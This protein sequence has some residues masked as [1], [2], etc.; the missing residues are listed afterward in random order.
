MN[1]VISTTREEESQKVGDHELVLIKDDA[2]NRGE[3]RIVEELY[4]GR[5]GVV[6]GAKLKSRK[7][8]IDRALQHLYPLELPRQTKQDN[9]E[10]KS[11]KELD[12]NPGA[13]E[14]RPKPKAATV[15]RQGIKAVLNFED[16]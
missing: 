11:E 12:P 13:A 6:K 15:A 10:K 3:W 7:T 9:P 8:Y 2:R 1:D 4:Q 14:F 5:G 16:S